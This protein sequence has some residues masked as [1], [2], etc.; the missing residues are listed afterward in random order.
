M[1]HILYDNPK[2]NQSFISRYLSIPVHEWY[3]PRKERKIAGWIKGCVEVLKGSSRGDVIVCWF[4]F[5]AVLC[6][7][8]CRILRLKR[9]IICINLMLK[10][11]STLKNRI[12]SSMYK[13]ALLSSR[14]RASVTSVAYGEWLNRKL[15]ICVTYF[16]L[17]DVFRENYKYEAAKEDS[18][19]SVFCGGRNGRDW[20]FILKVAQAIPEVKFNIVMPREVYEKHLSEYRDNMNIRYDLSYAGFMEELCSSS[21]VCLPLDTEAPAGLIVLFQA[22]ANRKMVITTQTPSTS[23]YITPERGSALPNEI[24]EWV[25]AI[26]YFLDRKSEADGKALNLFEFLREECSEEAFV[27]GLERMIRGK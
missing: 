16:L 22:A 21:L 8:L 12:V 13:R 27:N 20:E 18:G 2:D 19:K 6:D 17:H 10:D 3:S 14:F 15:G 5:Q 23:E 7:W 24:E 11:K 4:D 26:R 9:D 1:I 25:C